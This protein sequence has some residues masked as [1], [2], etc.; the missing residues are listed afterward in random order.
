MIYQKGGE[1]ASRECPNCHSRK[2]WRDGI[3]R[4]VFGSIQRFVCRNCG[5]RFSESTVLSSDL[6]YTKDRQVCAAL[7]GAKN[8][9]TA[10]EI[11]TVAGETLRDCKD[12]ILQYA[13]WL[14]KKG[15][16]EA[17]ITS[18]VRRLRGLAK[19][20]NLM[21]SESV[22]EMLANSEAK[23]STKAI[24]AS[25]YT[26]FLKCFGLQWEKPDYTI[27]RAIPFIPLESEI[28]QLIAGCSR[29]TATLLQLLKETGIRI[30]EAARMKWVDFDAERRTVRVLAEKRSNPRIARISEKLV[31]MLDL[32]PKRSEYIFHTN[33]DMLRNIFDIQRKR[34]ALK[35]N[36]P[37][38]AKITFHTL[39][40]WR[41]TMEY[42]KTKD[43]DHVRRVLGHKHLQSTETY[44]NIEQAVF[45]ESSD[46]FSVKVAHNLKEGCQLIES[47]FEYVTELD[48]FKV[49]K[50]RK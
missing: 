26:D 24:T 2:N 16:R 1:E 11:K 31:G 30:G 8:L 50:K 14:K 36:N 23:D 32:L 46:E 17:T 45:P 37:R 40:H 41:G 28:D 43:S 42:H 5:H 20:C 18:R 12:R 25:V 29:R 22:K 33:A 38:I 34:I 47:G 15:R 4:T 35:L 10:T 21:E 27:E 6:Y 9:G 19:N 49:F 13:W 3:R 44:I 39:R 48:G 7:I